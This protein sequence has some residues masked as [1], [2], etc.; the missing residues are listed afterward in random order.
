MHNRAAH[1]P[2]RTDQADKEND[3]RGKQPQSL[4]FAA[5]FVDEESKPQCHSKSHYPS[6]ESGSKGEG[7]HS[8]DSVPFCN[9][10]FGNFYIGHF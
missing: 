4:Q 6:E 5:T 2:L 9:P 7:R 3:K 1:L 10:T 8:Q